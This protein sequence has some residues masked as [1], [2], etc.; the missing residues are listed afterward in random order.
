MNTERVEYI[1]VGMYHQE[2]GWPKDVDPTEKEQTTRYRKKVEKDEEYIRQIKSL[3]DS[4][5]HSIMQNN[6]VDIYQEYFSGEYADHSSDPPSAK[7]LSVFKCVAARPRRAPAPPRPPASNR[8]PAATPAPGLAPTPRLSRRRDPNT[9]KRT[10]SNISWYPDGGKKLAVA[11]AIMQFQDWRMDK[12]SNLSYIWDVNN[13][14]FPE[15]VHT[16][17]RSRPPPSPSPS[18]SPSLHPPRARA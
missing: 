6:A 10:V 18:P 2:G 3:G 7:T 12:M 8:P 15:Q 14:N 1:S 5:E 16:R 13:P 4:V 11:F 9:V 17:P